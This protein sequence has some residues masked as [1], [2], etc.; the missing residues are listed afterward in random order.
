MDIA[1]VDK[2]E[3]YAVI[4]GAFFGNFLICLPAHPYTLCC[5]SYCVVVCMRTPVQIHSFTRAHTQTRS[6][7]R[8]TNFFFKLME[9]SPWS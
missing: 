6:H 7:A 3:E 9:D 1:A 5:S 2:N 8:R 4:V